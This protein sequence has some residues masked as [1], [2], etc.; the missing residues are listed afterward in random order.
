LVVK[1]YTKNEVV[2]KQL[3][4]ERIPNLDVYDSVTMSTG[5]WKIGEI[6]QDTGHNQIVEVFRG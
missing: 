2:R 1:T 5:K 3:L 4:I 6:L